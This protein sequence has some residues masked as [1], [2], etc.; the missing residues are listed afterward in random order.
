[1][2]AD[3]ER[4]VFGPVPSRRLGNSLGVNNIPPKSCSYACIYCQLGRTYPM[5]VRRQAFYAPELV[6]ERVK[7]RLAEARRAKAP[8]DYIT[9]V[10]DGEPA[11]DANLGHEISLLRSLQL[12]VAVITNASLIW[13]EDVRQELLHADWVSLKVDAVSPDVWRS[14]DRPHGS[15]RLAAILDGALAFAQAYPGELVTETM[16]VRGVNDGAQP[17]R[18]LAEFLARLKPRRA[19]LAVPTRPPAEPWVRAP[20]E[21]T[22]LE[23]YQIVSERI[24]RVEYLIGYEGNAFSSMG[25]PEQDL[26]AITAVHPMRSDAI[27][28]FLAKAG[29]G[30]AVVEDLVARGE[31]VASEYRGHTYYVKKLHQR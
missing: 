7:A 4:L 2:N 31:I 13:R 28:E 30:W 10:A 24:P 5:Q 16:L 9:F 8:I 27:Q 3:L 21:E 23:A 25:D 6:L 12:P 29:S 20:V 15:L 19:Y 14:V 26:L 22:L 1:M 11:L 18:A 17:I